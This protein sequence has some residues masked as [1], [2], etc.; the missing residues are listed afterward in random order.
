MP[1][2]TLRFESL[3]PAFSMTKILCRYEGDLHCLAEH[4]LSGVEIHTDAPLD[5]DGLGESFSPTDLLA[6]ALGTCILTVMGITAKRRGW[7]LGEVQADVEKIMTLEGP[8]RIDALEVYL[9][10]PDGLTDDQLSLLRKVVDTC[11]V[12]RNLEP[13][14]NINLFWA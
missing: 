3:L 6:T 4:S 7:N 13:S 14:I 10:M 8:R 9:T 5:H 2:I 12:K 11:P 1:C